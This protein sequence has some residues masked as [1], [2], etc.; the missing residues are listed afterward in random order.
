M[1]CTKQDPGLRA[2]QRNAQFPASRA[3]TVTRA[4]ALSNLAA[5]GCMQQRNT[6]REANGYTA[7]PRQQCDTE[8]VYA[9]IA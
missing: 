4:D 3:G 9:V 1:L 8:G 5:A 6:E 2:L 7:Q